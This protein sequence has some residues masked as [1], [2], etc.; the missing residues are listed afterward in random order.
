[1]YFEVFV[2]STRKIHVFVKLFL[3]S[4]YAQMHSQ[5]FGT[6]QIFL[7]IFSQKCHASFWNYFEG[8][9][10]CF[11]PWKYSNSLLHA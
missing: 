9:N 4:A 5:S 2:H 11:L 10:S 3:Y 8:F 7:L 1:M 6:F